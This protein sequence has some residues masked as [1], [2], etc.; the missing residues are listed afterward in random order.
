MKTA[1]ARYLGT[2]IVLLALAAGC[3]AAG[4]GDI[5]TRENSAP[6]ARVGPD[7]SI[8]VNDTLLLD[9]TASFDQDEDSLSFEWTFLKRPA[10]SSTRLT[11]DRRPRPRF[12]PDV[13]GVYSVLLAVSDGRAAGRDTM[14]VDV[15]TADTIHIT[16][17]IRAERTLTNAVYLVPQ[18]IHVEEHLTIEP[19][20]TLLF[21]ARAGLRVIG[22]RLGVIEALGTAQEPIR[23]VGTCEEPGHW[24]GLLFERSHRNKLE[25]VEVGFG[26]GSPLASSSRPA[27]ITVGDNAELS[28]RHARVHDSAGQGLLVQGELRG[29]ENN[30]FTNNQDVP[31]TIPLSEIGKIDATSR[32]ADNAKS[33]VSVH[34]ELARGSG[35]RIA[36][37][38]LPYRLQGKGALGQPTRIEP[39]VELILAKRASLA[40]EKP[41]QAEGTANQ[42]IIVRGAEPGAGYWGGFILGGAGTLRH[43]QITGAARVQASTGDLTLSHSRL[44]DIGSHGFVIGG[45]VHMLSFSDSEIRRSAG[46]LLVAPIRMLEEIAEGLKLTDDTDPYI[47]I[48]FD[49]STDRSIRLPSVGIPYR[50]WQYVDFPDRLKIEPGVTI[51]FHPEAAFNI[52]GQLEAVGSTYSDNA[53]GDIERVTE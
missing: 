51:Q 39:G 14:Q 46:P 47:G 40:F 10:G 26:G 42:P 8:G 2:L 23:F 22:S 33:H 4:P 52:R 30:T 41:L 50:V 19:G 45:G 35:G 6:V 18:V 7:T 38:G 43:V 48:R 3:D 25:H 49:T 5:R 32:F 29:F 28:L 53:R 12:E 27:N 24:R 1:S 11:D 37:I 16:Q 31:L 9:G 21:G 36:A 15:A 20:V 13:P 44:E 17:H 34:G